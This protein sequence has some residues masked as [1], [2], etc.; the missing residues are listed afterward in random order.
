MDI[1]KKL[2]VLCLIDDPT[3]IVYFNVYEVDDIW[4][5]IQGCEACSLENR[6]K[7][8]NLCPM[9]TELGCYFHLENLLNKPYRCV[10]K[11]TPETCLSWCALEFKCVKGKNEGKI[12]KIKDIGNVFH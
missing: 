3:P 1:T 9:F 7:C 4:I 6:K 2:S 11:P 5:K 10:V 8:C 12:R